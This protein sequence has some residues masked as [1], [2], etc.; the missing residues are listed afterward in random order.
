M[1]SK[2]YLLLHRS[3]TE[4]REPPSPAQ[5]QEMFAVWTAWKEKFKDNILDM[6]GKLGPGGKVLTTSG[7]MDGPFV[8]AKEIVGGYMIVA[9]D[10]YEQAM[11]VAKEGPGMVMPGTRVE[12]REITRS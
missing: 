1:P 9:A 8:E 12:I 5:M 11:E 2:K 3:S 6:G 7:V 4:Q 10:S